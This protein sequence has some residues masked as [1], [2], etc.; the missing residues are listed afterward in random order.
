MNTVEARPNNATSGRVTVVSRQAWL[1]IYY[2]YA[3]IE[4]EKYQPDE[5]QRRVRSRRGAIQLSSASAD[6][7]GISCCVPT[8]SKPIAK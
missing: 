3:T 8:Q 4:D 7:R 2:N 5:L 6:Q 1:K